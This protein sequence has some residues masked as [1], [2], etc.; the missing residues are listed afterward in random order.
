[1]SRSAVCFSVIRTRGSDAASA[2]S[3]AAWSGGTVRSTSSPPWGAMTWPRLCVAVSGD[4]RRRPLPAPAPGSPAARARPARGRPTPRA[5]TFGRD[6]D[7]RVVRG[8]VGVGDPGELLDLAGAS[9]GVQ[10]LQVA[11]LA[12]LQGGR[13]VHLAEAV[14]DHLADHV[15]GLDVRRDGRTDHARAVPRQQLGHEPDAEDVGVAVLTAEAEALR[16]V[17][18]H[19]VAVEVL[20]QHAA[21]LD[22]RPDQL[23]DGALPGPGQAGEPDGESRCSPAVILSKVLSF[24]GCPLSGMEAAL[25]LSG[26]PPPSRP[27]V[28]RVAVHRTGARNAPDRRIA[29]VVQRV[30]RNAMPPDVAPDVAARPVGKGLNLDDAAAFVQ[31]DFACI[32]T[33]CRLFAS[34]TRHPRVHSHAAPVAVARPSGC[35]SRRRDPAPRADLRASRPAPRRSIRAR[36]S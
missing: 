35:R 3:S 8:L 24:R 14:A 31:L 21:P 20:D 36:S 16:Q 29:V 2:A 1:M 9:L 5:A 32:L 6:H 23:G 15:A 10:A 30:V 7:L 13:D 11:P 26:A 17:G 22:L 33:R 18:A 28:G 27:L 19:D 4:I 25:D 12:L 34:N